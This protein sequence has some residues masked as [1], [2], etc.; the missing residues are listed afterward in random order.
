MLTKEYELGLWRG[1]VDTVLSSRQYAHVHI[2]LDQGDQWSSHSEVLT[3]PYVLHG[4]WV[5]N[6]SIQPIEVR[7]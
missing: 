4:L 1:V 3:V 5:R 2:P 7:G 6:R